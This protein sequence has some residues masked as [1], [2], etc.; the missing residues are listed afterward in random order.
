MDVSYNTS[1]K[2][3]F[4]E[5]IEPKR[6]CKENESEEISRMNATLLGQR[7]KR[8][9]GGE[10]SEEVGRWCE[11]T[12]GKKSDSLSSSSDDD[13]DSAT[14]VQPRKKSRGTTG[15]QMSGG[16]RSVRD[17]RGA[18]VAKGKKSGTGASAVKGKK[19]PDYKS[20]DISLSSDDSTQ[21]ATKGKH[22]IKDLLK[23]T[24]EK[25]KMIRSLDLK[26]S[27]TKVTSRINKTE[28]REEMKWMGEETNF[29]KTVN[30][31]C[32]IFLFPK[33]KFLKYGWKD[34]M[35]DKKNSF[36]SLCMH[37]LKIPKGADKKDIWDRVIVPSVMRKYQHMKCNLNNDIKS[38]YMMMT[39]FLCES[40]FTVLV[41]YTGIYFILCLNNTGKRT[42]VWPDELGKGFQDLCKTQP[43]ACGV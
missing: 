32:R 3:T 7:I 24:K 31:F 34:I 12:D 35:P 2:K 23:K 1:H 27:K 30:H 16:T 17:S 22:S 5:F 9:I 39:T 38:L 15:G 14:S 43:G 33:F 37:H 25:D 10:R 6:G 13:S 19:T 41:N 4:H 40:T 20:D 8:T 26:L 11:E 36:Y 29:A 21:K 42:R 28:V 18:K